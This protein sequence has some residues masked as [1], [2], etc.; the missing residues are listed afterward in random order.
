MYYQ[1]M[2]SV[3][4][5]EVVLFQLVMCSIILSKSLLINSFFFVFVVVI[6]ANDEN[7]R[8]VSYCVISE[9]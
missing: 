6:T 3:S 9:L 7:V 4:L 1:H 2:L 8:T 5:A